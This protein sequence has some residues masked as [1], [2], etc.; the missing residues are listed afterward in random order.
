MIRSLVVDRSL[1]RDRPGYAARLFL[2]C[3][4][5]TVRGK[6]PRASLCGSVQCPIVRQDNTFVTRVT[7]FARFF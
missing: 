6:S 4:N 5:N 1:A 3:K 7:V 2:S